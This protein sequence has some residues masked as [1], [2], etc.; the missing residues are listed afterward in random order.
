MLAAR[1]DDDDDNPLNSQTFCFFFLP[2]DE[3]N[4]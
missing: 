3:L 2:R 1:H 4:K